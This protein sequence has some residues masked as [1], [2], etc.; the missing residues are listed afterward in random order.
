MAEFK[1][2]IDCTSCGNKNTVSVI[3]K[4]TKYSRSVKVTKCN[5]CGHQAGVKA[6]L[7]ATQRKMY[8]L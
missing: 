2:M 3:T 8:V 4:Q 6:T 1:Q 5:V 7:N